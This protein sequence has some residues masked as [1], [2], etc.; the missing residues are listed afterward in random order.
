MGL[1]FLVRWSFRQRTKCTDWKD[2]SGWRMIDHDH[3]HHYSTV[4][5][6]VPSLH[7]T[8]WIIMMYV[9]MP[10]CLTSFIDEVWLFDKV[11]LTWN[12][13]KLYRDTCQ[14]AWHLLLKDHFVTRSALDSRGRAAQA[15]SE[16][17]EVRRRSE[18]KCCQC[19][20]VL[21]TVCQPPSQNGENWRERK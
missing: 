7:S 18:C 15:P 6:S 13:G 8:E 1:F 21:V 16:N 14:W 5:L 10:W 11:L 3:L 20:A 2:R 19:K 17:G 9:H 12:T 4:T